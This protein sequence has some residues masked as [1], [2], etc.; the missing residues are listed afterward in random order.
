[1]H[2]AGGRRVCLYCHKAVHTET[3]RITKRK[4]QQAQRKERQA[5]SSLQQSAWAPSNADKA[6]DD[7][8]DDD[9]RGSVARHA[10]SQARRPNPTPPTHDADNHT[11]DNHDDNFDGNDSD[12]DT[13]PEDFDERTGPGSRSDDEEM[14]DAQDDTTDTPLTTTTSTTRTSGRAA[15]SMAFANKRATRSQTRNQ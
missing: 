1:V 7:Q 8:D 5:S 4:R 11:N 2:V 6:W 3:C 15:S 12:N 10:A 13:L 9:I 14:A